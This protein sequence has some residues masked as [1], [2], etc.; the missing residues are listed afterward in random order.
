MN[1]IGPW[2]EAYDAQQQSWRQGQVAVRK[3]GDLAHQAGRPLP[4]LSMLMDGCIEK[5]V[6][7]TR[8]GTK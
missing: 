4:Y 7:V 8:G 5:G 3:A 1:K 6:D 2:R